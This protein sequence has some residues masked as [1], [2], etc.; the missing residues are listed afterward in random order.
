MDKYDCNLE[1]RH[2]FERNFTKEFSNT[3]YKSVKTGFTVYHKFKLEN[4]GFFDGYNKGTALQSHLLKFAIEN[5]VSKSAFTPTSSHRAVVG[6]LNDYGY[7]GLFLRT[8]D[9]IITLCKTYKPMRLPS[10]AQHRKQLAAVNNSL[11]TQLRLDMGG[12]VVDDSFKYSIITY[13]SNSSFE[14]SHLNIITPE[15]DYSGII[16]DFST[17]IMR[18]DNLVAMPDIVTEEQVV[19]L[20]K[21]FQISLKQ[22]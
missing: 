6:K 15:L 12:F 7:N 19:A 9:F 11:A 22:G 8:D 20:K 2:L 13:G 3:I 17:D 21:E 1:F 14:L 4:K 18:D 5:E 16:S 10:Y